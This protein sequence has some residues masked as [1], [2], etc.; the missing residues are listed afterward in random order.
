MIT[1]L[2][3]NLDMDQILKIG[4]SLAGLS[5]AIYGVHR[6]PNLFTDDKND[7]N[8]RKNDL[9]NQKIEECSLKDL[10]DLCKQ[11]NAEIA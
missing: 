11:D 2:L 7:D 9:S 6:F 3:N 4:F 8:N 10:C 5:F 1:N